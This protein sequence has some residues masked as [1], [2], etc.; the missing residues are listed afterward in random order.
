MNGGQP[1]EA[2]MQQAQVPSEDDAL[3]VKPEDSAG[4]ANLHLLEILTSLTFSRILPL[5]LI[6]HT[7]GHS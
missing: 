2:A 1:E 4:M 6:L 5:G 3:P 7:N